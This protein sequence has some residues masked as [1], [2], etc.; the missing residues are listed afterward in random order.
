MNEQPVFPAVL[1][2]ALDQ[3]GMKRYRLA[4]KSGVSASAIC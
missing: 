3:S 2:C 1:Q 4:E